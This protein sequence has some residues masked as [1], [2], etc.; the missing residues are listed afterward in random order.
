MALARENPQAYEEWLEESGAEGL[1]E[2]EQERLIE[3]EEQ[4]QRGRGLSPSPAGG[5]RRKPR[6]EGRIDFILLRLRMRRLHRSVPWPALLEGLG[7]LFGDLRSWEEAKRAYRRWKRAR[8]ES[9][10]KSI[11]KLRR[12]PPRRDS[13]EQWKREVGLSQ[14]EREGTSK[15]T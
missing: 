8:R 15:G 9:W 13:Y 14:T 6:R 5:I 12:L 11:Q 2:H 4:R 3:E 7:L 1:E 10:K